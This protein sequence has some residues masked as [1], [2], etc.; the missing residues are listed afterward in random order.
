MKDEKAL[1]LVIG[2]DK[3]AF[4]EQMTKK[5]ELPDVSKAVR[6]LIDHARENPS[7]QDSIFNELRCLDC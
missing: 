2:S 1:E 4:L 3:L 5:Y 7:M 6:I